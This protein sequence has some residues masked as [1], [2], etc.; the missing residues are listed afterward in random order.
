MK[1]V[2]FKD[3]FLAKD[4]ESTIN[5]AVTSTNRLHTP[6]RPQVLLRHEILPLLQR[7]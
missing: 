3:N 4:V 6:I 1:T 2:Y 5:Q 7:L